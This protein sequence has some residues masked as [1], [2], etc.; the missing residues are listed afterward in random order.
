MAATAWLVLVLDFGIAG[1]AFGSVIAETVGLAVGLMVISRLGGGW[2]NVSRATILRRDKLMRMLS[3]NR[4]IMIR[5]AALISAFAFFTAQGARAGDVTLAANAVLHNFILIGSFCPRRH[6]GGG[7]T[8]LR[9][10]HRRQEPRG[11]PARGAAGHHLGLRLRHC[12]FAR[13][14]CRR[15]QFIALITTNEAVRAAAGVF[16][17]FAVLAP[18]L[19]VAAYIFDGIYIGATW[20]RDMRNLMVAALT[21]YLVMWWSLQSLGNG[22]LWLALLI[23]LAARGLLQAA[24]FPALARMTFQ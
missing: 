8:D 24:R 10:N 2:T 11:L 21:I 12:D 18:I 16:M 20:T 3:V 7:R 22:G 4:D 14:V 6:G 17:L 15:R 13:A 19:G 5:T 1:A 9:P 23:F